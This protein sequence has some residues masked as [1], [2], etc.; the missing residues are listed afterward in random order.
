VKKHT[1]VRELNICGADEAIFG[2]YM[3]EWYEA[4]S[5]YVRAFW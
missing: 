5:S 3:Y 4:G 1:I 2:K